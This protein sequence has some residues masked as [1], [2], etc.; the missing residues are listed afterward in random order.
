MV[1]DARVYVK[2]V[3]IHSE[4]NIR[5]H[6]VFPSNWWFNVDQPKMYFRIFKTIILSV[7]EK[8]RSHAAYR[9]KSRKYRYTKN[10]RP[11]SWTGHAHPKKHTKRQR[12]VEEKVYI[13][14][15]S[16]FLLLMKPKN[17]NKKLLIKRH[18]EKLCYLSGWLRK[19]MNIVGERDNL[20]PIK[21][22]VYKAIEVA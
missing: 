22:T 19:W 20:V 8:N 7:W 21:L 16:L 10:K 11:I 17:L 9:W 1:C 14:C 3:K 5:I 15:D 12:D 18:R 4:I 2:P 6:A 13:S